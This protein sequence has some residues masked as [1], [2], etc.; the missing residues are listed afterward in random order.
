MR[1]HAR[2]VPIC[3]QEPVMGRLEMVAGANGK[4]SSD[5]ILCAKDGEAPCVSSRG[6]AG[7][8]GLG[9]Q[10]SAWSQELGAPAVVGV[11]GLDYLENGDVVVLLPNGVVNVLYRKSSRH[12]TILATERCNSLCLM[13]SQPPKEI[14][15]SYRVNEILHLLEL[16]DRSCVELGLSGGEPTLLGDDFIRIVQQSKDQLP[17]TAFHVLTNG[18]LFTDRDFARRLAE[19]QHQDLMLG[20]PLYSDIDEEHDYVV[21]ARGAFEETMAGLHNLAEAG[22][23]VEIRVVLHALTYERLPQLSEFIYRNLPFAS[24]V[25][26]MGLE[27]FGYVPQNLSVL[28]VDPTAYQGQL[29]RAVTNLALRGMNVSVYNHQLCTVPRSIWPFTRKSISDWKN[30]YLDACN[31]CTV[32]DL[33]G[34]FFQ[35][36]TKVHSDSIAPPAP[37]ESFEFERLRELVGA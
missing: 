28:W 36:A 8:L 23:R 30:V 16:V 32:R 10:T 24:H 25:A 35:S 33:C 27:M 26:L 19:V 15:D 20:I 2:G 17:S 1:L 13:C 31:G 11:S 9:T 4:A 7:F 37:L 34:G 29:E 6:C 22:V 12:N 3:I 18:R 21:Q 14:D 5:S